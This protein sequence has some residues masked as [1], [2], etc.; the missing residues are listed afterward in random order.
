MPVHYGGYPCRLHELQALAHRHGVAVVED[1]A[2][3]F[4][5]LYDGRP[6]GST[7]NVACF[8]FDPV[9]N[10][11]CGE[12]GA[13]TTDDDEL[14]HRVNL[15][16]NL[17][18]PGDSWARRSARR[19]WFYEAVGTGMRHHMSDV[20][21]AIGLAQLDRMDAIRT[22]KR[23]IIR[24][25]LNGLAGIPGIQPLAGDV[26]QA[27]PFLFALRVTDGSRDELVRALA[28]R[29]IQAWVHFVP[30]HLQPAF[31][32]YARPLPV[33]E[34]LYGELVSLPL[35]AELTDEQV[36]FVVGAVH[37]AQRLAA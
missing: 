23:E 7:G 12:G 9:K 29:G 21:A 4:G 10:V 2:H 22:R 11:T 5:S 33:T 31:A 37:D 17:G 35:F 30:L 3:A 14:A 18:V 32:R 25:Y 16:R 8:S 20:N 13:V 26:T 1:A 34:Q 36:D 6:I 24:R 15:L 28:E 19:P 27:F